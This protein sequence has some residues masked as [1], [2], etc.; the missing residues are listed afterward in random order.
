MVFRQ[1]REKRELP[2]NEKSESTKEKKPELGIGRR[3]LY[4]RVTKTSQ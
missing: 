1:E 4:H 3:R 2:V